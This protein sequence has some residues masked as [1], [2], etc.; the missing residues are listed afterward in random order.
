MKERLTA[1]AIDGTL[2]YDAN[3]FLEKEVRYQ[4]RLMLIDGRLE[5]YARRYLPGTRNVSGVMNGW[6]NLTGRGMDTNRMTGNGQFRISPAAL[7]ELPILV[8]VFQVLTL[9]GPDHTAF[10]FAFVDFD[11]ANNQF[12]F[13]TIDLTGESLRL[14]GRGTAGFDGRL[15]L[16]FYSE[17]PR[18][19]LPWPVVNLINPVLDQATKDWVRVEVRGKTGNP[20]VKAKPLPV[21]EDSVKRFLGILGNG[22]PTLPADRQIRSP[23]GRRK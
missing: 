17:L 2:T 21:L 1:Q 18:A 15:N 8:K 10:Q 19:R 7:Y 5:E 14:Q 6:L 9:A 4:S 11:L 20:D 23:F 13:N 16:D 22:M 3:I 12:V